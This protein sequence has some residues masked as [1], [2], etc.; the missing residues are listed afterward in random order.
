MSIAINYE[1]SF[2]SCVHFFKSDRFS[3]EAY[4]ASSDKFLALLTVPHMG[5]S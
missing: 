3:F 5:S 2:Y 4:D 1:K